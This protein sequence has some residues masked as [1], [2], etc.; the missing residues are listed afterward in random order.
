MVKPLKTEYLKRTTAAE[1]ERSCSENDR[2]YV[3]LYGSSVD[4]FGDTATVG[5]IRA[6][7][8]K[9]IDHVARYQLSHLHLNIGIVGRFVTTVCELIS[10][11][12]AKSLPADEWWK[13]DLVGALRFYN[14]FE[15]LFPLMVRK[16]VKFGGNSWIKLAE[17][18]FPKPTTRTPLFTDY[19]IIYWVKRHEAKDKEEDPIKALARAFSIA[20]LYK[21]PDTF[22]LRELEVQEARDFLRRYPAWFLNE[23][24]GSEAVAA[25]NAWLNS[26]ERYGA[27]PKSELEVLVERV[28]KLEKAIGISGDDDIDVLQFANRLLDVS[29]KDEAVF[30]VAQS[31]AREFCEKYFEILWDKGTDKGIGGGLAL[32]PED[33]EFEIWKYEKWKQLQILRRVDKLLRLIGR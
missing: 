11:P 16:E 1:R 12:L 26:T 32:S 31:E 29:A 15:N 24:V 33:V 17:A 10:E 6:L 21:L 5:S 3:S 19:N 20:A 9:L 28:E 13:T 14:M 4:S 7:A 23:L 25:I 2:Y 27:K 8:E 18:A 22:D 30:S